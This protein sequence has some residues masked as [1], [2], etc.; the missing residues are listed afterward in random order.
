MATFPNTK[1]IGNFSAWLITNKYLLILLLVTGTMYVP[2]LGYP[3]TWDDAMMLQQN[4]VLADIANIKL[5]F[6]QNYLEAIV[7]TNEAV[8]YYRPISLAIIFIERAVFG[9]YPVGYRIVS[10]LLHM[11]SISLLFFFLKR[12][13]YNDAP[14]WGSSDTTA[15]RAEFAAFIGML[16]FIVVPYSVDAVIFV[17]NQGE[18]FVLF[19]TLINVLLFNKYLSNGRHWLLAIIFFTTLLAAGSK[20]TGT[21]IPV[22]LGLTAIATKK[23]FTPSVWRAIL[24]SLSA[25][26]LFVVL[27]TF[28]ISNTVQFDPL[29][30]LLTFPLHFLQAIRWGLLPH[31]LALTDPSPGP[32]SLNAW[33]IASYLACVVYTIALILAYKRNR[34]IFT[35]LSLWGILIAPSLVAMHFSPVFSSRYLYLPAIGISILLAYAILRFP[36][37]S[38]ITSAMLA[39]VSLLLLAIIRLSAWQSETELWKLETE[40]QPTE[41]GPLNNLAAALMDDRQFEKALPLYW[42]LLKLAKTRGDLKFT[43][44]AYD[45]LAWFSEHRFKN[46]KKAF[47]LYKKSIQTYPTHLAWIGL[48]RLHAQDKNY[49]KAKECFKKAEELRPN[50]F[51]TLVYIET[52]SATM[53]DFD[54]ALEYNTRLQN[55]VADKPDALEGIRNRRKIILKSMAKANSLPAIAP[56]DK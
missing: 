27:R 1:F 51:E 13:L 52:I 14:L 29:N 19:L 22:I 49:Q 38:I 3:L 46:D 2:V 18:L 26:I 34:I 8:P 10:L 28:V 23:G 43:A 32:A 4:A 21:I 42:K 11:G 36:L 7:N 15:A 41:M 33:T 45:K 17:T 50:S 9:L 40:R 48:G 54:K 37:K 16:F 20:E 6:T 25:S 31:P 47:S 56:Q 30:M 24:A 12:L 5:A 55:F 39:Y 53:G 44:L 35:G